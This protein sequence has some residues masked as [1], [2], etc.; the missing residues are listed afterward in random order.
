Q[1]AEQAVK[2]AEVYLTYTEIQAPVAGR[3]VD[4]LV[5]AGDTATP[6]QTLLNLYDPKAL[7]LEASV[8][9][10]LATDLKIGQ[11]LSVT[12]DNP[13]LKMEGS[14]EEIVPQADVASRSFLVKV[15]LPH[16]ERLFTG[17][18]GRLS[19]PSGERVRL[20]IPEAAVER[21]GQL[22]FVTVVKKD[23]THEH[24]F[25]KTGI[26]REQGKIEALSGVAADERIL[27]PAGAEVS[28]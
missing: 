4:K 26:H 21:S 17:S 24:R 9:A 2:E 23:G 27:I 16:D 13:P 28:H 1:Q 18:Y 20:C 10:S 15:A 22:E 6:G 12:I 7:R 3:V 19:I 5:D 11:P 14:I 25:I 8:P